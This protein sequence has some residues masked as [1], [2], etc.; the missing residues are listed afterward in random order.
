MGLHYAA[1]CDKELYVRKR[2]RAERV[3][4]FVLGLW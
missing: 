4:D 1:A 2:W 3:A